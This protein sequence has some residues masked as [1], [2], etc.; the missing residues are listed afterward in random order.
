VRR[1]ALV[2]A[3]GVAAVVALVLAVRGFSAGPGPACPRTTNPNWNPYDGTAA[4]ARACGLT[5][6]PLTSTTTLPDGGRQYVYQGPDNAPITQDIPPAGF[7]AV[8]ASAAERALY[9]L[10]PEPPASNPIA[11]AHWVREI[12]GMK[13]WV[14]ATS[15]VYSTPG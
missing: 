14:P 3:V 1:V 7:N 12:E 2:A 13:S 10:P 4:Q 5:V 11:R 6:Y 8:T 9:G 15:F